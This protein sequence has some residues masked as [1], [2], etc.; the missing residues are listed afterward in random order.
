MEAGFL[1]YVQAGGKSNNLF[2]QAPNYPLAAKTAELISVMYR[3]TA[4][5]TAVL[6][7]VWVCL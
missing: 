2:G 1:K 4:G 5:M 3:Q 6:L 7:T